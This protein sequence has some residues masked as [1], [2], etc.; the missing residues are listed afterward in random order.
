MPEIEI[1]VQFVNAPKAGKRLGSIKSSEGE[2]YG[3]D[4]ATLGRFSKGEVCTIEYTETPKDGG[5][6][7]KNIKRKISTSSA[8]PAPSIRN[9]TDPK[10]SEQMFVTAL[11]KE[12]L[13]SG[14][15]EPTGAAIVAC[16]SAF[17]QAYRQLFGDAAKQ[18]TEAVMRDEIP[19]EF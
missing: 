17:K 9:R 18:T 11:L 13:G 3:C 5:G 10:D 1:T 7:W 19:D 2:Y 14:K 6:T 4:P 15:I 12:A 16:G 8:P